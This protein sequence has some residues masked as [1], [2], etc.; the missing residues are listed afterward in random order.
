MSGSITKAGN[1]TTRPLIFNPRLK[2]TIIRNFKRKKLN[3]IGDFDILTEERVRKE[4]RLAYIPGG[5][6]YKQIH[7][8]EKSQ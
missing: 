1:K 8:K 2:H 3:L 6:L 5:G 4:W 7:T